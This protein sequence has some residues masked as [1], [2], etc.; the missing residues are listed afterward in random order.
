M[1]FDI[2]KYDTGKPNPRNSGQN[3][4]RF[5]KIYLNP[6]STLNTSDKKGKNSI[7]YLVK[8]IQGKHKIAIIAYKFF[9]RCR[10]YFLARCL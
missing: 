1:P 9:N 4:F 5:R 6:P 8:R 3:K 7:Y 2:R 10:R